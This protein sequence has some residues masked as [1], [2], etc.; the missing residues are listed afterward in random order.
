[1]LCYF[2]Y[3]IGDAAVYILSHYDRRVKTFNTPLEMRLPT[4][5][6]CSSPPTE[7]F[8]YSIGDVHFQLRRVNLPQRAGLSILHWRCAARRAFTGCAT[9][10]SFNTPL[11]MPA[12]Q[13]SR[14]D[15]VRMAILSILHWRCVNSVPRN[16]SWLV[17][18]SF[19]TPLEMP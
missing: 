8:Q 14:S 11:E 19:N 15:V 12:L 2:Q 9:G 7:T 17:D 16:E 6:S 10:S 13:V 5:N 1:M 4:T 18:Y 3:S